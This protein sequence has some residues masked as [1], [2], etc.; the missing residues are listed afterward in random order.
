MKCRKGVMPER[1]EQQVEPHHIRIDFADAPQDLS[2]T[3]AIVEIPATDD[4]GLVL[5]DLGDR[6]R[7]NSEAQQGTLAQFTRQMETIFAQAATTG[8]EGGNQANL[9][10]SPSGLW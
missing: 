7:Q 4:I 2:R 5:L 8:R 9:H 1:S 6:I 3:P 10:R